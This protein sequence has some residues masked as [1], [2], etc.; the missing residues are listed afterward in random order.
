MF[1]IVTFPVLMYLFNTTKTKNLNLQNTISTP[2]PPS[3][4]TYTRTNFW[5][6][7]TNTHSRAFET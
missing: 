1:D 3:S 6:T 7:L 5:A 4:L 2:P